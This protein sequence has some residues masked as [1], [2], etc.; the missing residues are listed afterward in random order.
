L[1]AARTGN[2]DGPDAGT[3]GK[4][5]RMMAGSAGRRHAHQFP[6]FSRGPA[7]RPASTR[8]M[9]V[10]AGQATPSAWLAARAAICAGGPGGTTW[11]G[12]SR[13]TRPMAGYPASG[14]AFLCAIRGWP[15]QRD[16]V[17]V[18]GGWP[19]NR[20]L[21]PLHTAGDSTGLSADT[22]RYRGLS[23]ARNSF[24]RPPESHPHRPPQ[25]SQSRSCPAG[26]A[27]L[28]RPAPGQPGSGPVPGHARGARLAGS[29][30]RPT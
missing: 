23:R 4:P 27:R 19:A 28:P 21:I 3:P 10:H 15:A 25:P 5:A 17:A 11:L 8:Q 29:G 30:L 9:P 18:P 13:R 16:Q 12:G 26:P 1:P 22:S 6:A 14:V 7:G 24:R 20:P 2:P